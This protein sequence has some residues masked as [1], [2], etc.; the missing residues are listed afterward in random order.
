[1]LMLKQYFPRYFP[2]ISKPFPKNLKFNP[3]LQF[4]IDLIEICIALIA[5][6][7]IESELLY[8]FSGGTVD[9]TV[10]ETQTDG[11][12][13]E[14][15]KANGGPWGG[16]NVDKAFIEFLEDIAG[17]DVIDAFIR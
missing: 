15:Y 16:T 3:Y 2:V 11:T 6:Q 4:H 10:H 7:H 12:V 13:R 1:M 8:L 17:K 5:K 14:L 9:I